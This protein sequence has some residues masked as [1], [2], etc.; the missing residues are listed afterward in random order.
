MPRS[1]IP[2]KTNIF[3]TSH[4]T[5][6]SFP[7]RE[8]KNPFSLGSSMLSP[9]IPHPKSAADIISPHSPSST[10][11]PVTAWSKKLGEYIK[12][13][14]KNSNLKKRSQTIL[15]NCHD[16]AEECGHFIFEG[17]PGEKQW[18]ASLLNFMVS[19]QHTEVNLSELQGYEKHVIVEIIKEK[20]HKLFD[21][22][23]HGNRKNC[24]A[25][26]LYDTDQL[27]T[28]ALSYIKWMLE[29]FKG[30]NKVFFCC[31]DA[32]KVQSTKPLCTFVQLLEPSNEEILKVLAFI[33]NQE[34]IHS[35]HQL[36]NKIANNA[37]NNLTQAIR[38]FEATWHFKYIS[39]LKEA[40]VI[41]TGWED[42]IAN[43]ARN[44]I[45]DQKSICH[46]LYNIRELQNLLEHN[47]DPGF[48]FQALKEEL[49]RIPPE[50]L[51]PQFDKLYDEYQKNYTTKKYLA[52]AQQEEFGKRQNDPR[53]NVQQFMRIEAH[54]TTILNSKFAIDNQPEH[55]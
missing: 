4:D 35:P 39:S 13:D 5:R 15:R 11:S 27:S 16:K 23:L 46:G 47:A 18:A 29:K 20:N 30:C 37:R 26:I 14:K 42:K 52:S 34:G 33:A 1:F 50:Q 45:E 28:D 36:A 51:Q 48:I 21:T 31:S 8:R 9:V 22:I 40:Q 6:F 24:K 38:S 19:P 10:G 17:N 12:G 49:K 55:P 41:K 44:V 7:T 3:F 54:T 43:I 32:S 25:I 53:K 2:Q